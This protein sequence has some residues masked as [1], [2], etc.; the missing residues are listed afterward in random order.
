MDDDAVYIL[1]LWRAGA[2]TGVGDDAWRASLEDL[3]TR[4]R[5]VYADL[6]N[7]H[8]ALDERTAR[9]DGGEEDGE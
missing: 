4:R 7:L 1:R 6:D 8:A 5:C 3:R 2:G 9:R